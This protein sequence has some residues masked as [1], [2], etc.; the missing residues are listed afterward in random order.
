MHAE[1]TIHISGLEDMAGLAA[2]I[3]VKL[4]PGDVLLLSGDLGSGKTTFTQALAR[5]LG[6]TDVVTSPTFTIMGEYTADGRE[7]IAW[8]VHIDLY[9]I[10]ADQHD[11]DQPYITEVID[12][13]VTHKRVVVVEWPEKLDLTLA[14]AWKLSFVMGSQETERVVTVQE[15]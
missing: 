8:L 15:P 11:V 1:K 5:S 12:T 3:A 14:R 10:S 6:V 13:A 4:V 9:R 2:D 7:D